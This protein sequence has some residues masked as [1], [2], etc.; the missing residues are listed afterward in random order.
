MYEN[1]EKNG[2]KE[3]SLLEDLFYGGIRP[4]DSFQPDTPDIRRLT[5]EVN[6]LYEAIRGLLPKDNQHLIHDMMNSQM[7]LTTDNVACAFAEGFR[8]GVKMSAEVWGK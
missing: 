2:N 6:R 5:D 7:F 4:C 8:L 1:G 3:M